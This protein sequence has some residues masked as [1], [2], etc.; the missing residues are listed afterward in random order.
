MRTSFF[1]RLPLL[2]VLAGV[3]AGPSVPSARAASPAAPNDTE[4]VLYTFEAPDFTLG[5]LDGQQG[6][7]T[8][9][10]GDYS[11]TDVNPYA[12]AQHLRVTVSA[13][14]FGSAAFSPTLMGVGAGAYSIASTRIAIHNSGTGSDMIV[15]ALSAAANGYNPAGP[16]P[17]TRVRFAV[18][19]TITAL[20][21]GTVWAPTTGTIADTAYHELKVIAA[22]DGS[23]TIELCLD[24]ESI[25]TGLSIAATTGTASFIDSFGL[26]SFMP[27]GSVGST[28]DLDDMRIVDADAGR[29]ADAAAWNFDGVDAPALPTGW[30]TDAVGAGTPWET[31]SD[32][33]DSAPNAARAQ[34]AGA[35]G[36]AS[37]YSAPATVDA[38]G[39]TLR[40]RHRWNLESGADGGVLELS[41][42]GGA[43]VDVEQAGGHFLEAGY[44]GSLDGATNP[45]GARTAWTGA[46]ADFATTSVELPAAAAGHEVRF[47]WRLGTGAGGSV[48][49]D[50]GWWVDSVTL[51]TRELP[52]RPEAAVAPAS[53]EVTVEQGAAAAATLSIAN[54]GG[55]TLTYAIPGLDAPPASA[56]APAASLPAVPAADVPRAFTRGARVAAGL[57]G[58]TVPL[59]AG[60]GI[61]FA[62][63]DDATPVAPNSLSCGVPG[64][65]T[66][67]NSWWR[68]FYF[69]EHS[70]IGASARIDSVTIASE[71]GPD[72][73]VT[74]N[75]Y[76]IAHGDAP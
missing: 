46:Q 1:R 73:P 3:L 20:Q 51:A 54:L 52:T 49:G 17:V 36:E 15:A 58:R 75:L 47:R 8:D 67:A 60:A 69:D 29:C 64:V 39:G 70:R 10:D 35:A 65:S 18:D 34:A 2:G 45:L 9:W 27:D 28:A 63:M 76:T 43:F 21:P 42:D 74:I 16:L 5:E 31:E 66:D 33:A 41:I 55:G 37:L 50:A 56:A 7:T 61:D 11:I 38:V 57:R 62:Q 4:A 25:F 14:G 23:G 30:S 6:W 13:T 24:G 12:G 26:L 22:N 44:N 72:V 71:S 40:F 19:G 32:S 53:I 68:R 59:G 48:D